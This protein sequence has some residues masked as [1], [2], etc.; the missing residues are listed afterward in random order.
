[1]KNF[2]LPGTFLLLAL[3]TLGNA[4]KK[5]KALKRP[6]ALFLVFSCL[7]P[8]GCNSEDDASK[9]NWT[10]HTPS[11]PLPEGQGGLRVT[12]PEGADG[13]RWNVYDADNKEVRHEEPPGETTLLP[14]GTYLVVL[15]NELGEPPVAR[16]VPVHQGKITE[17]SLGAVLVT[18]PEGAKDGIW[19]LFDAAGE[20]QLLHEI[21]P[22][23]LY[24]LPQGTYQ[25]MD[26]RTPHTLVYGEQISIHAG[27]ATELNLAAVLVTV[28]E[29]AIGG[30]WDLYDVAGETQLLHEIS[31]NVPSAVPSGT[32]RLMDERTPNT[33]PYVEKI[34]FHAGTISKVDLGAILVTRTGLERWHLYDA[35]GKI[36]LLH[37][38]SAKVPC[39]V[40]A[41]T[42]QIKS[43]NETIIPRVTV[44]PGQLTTTQ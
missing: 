16:D 14:P 31:A 12:I 26:E 19:S 7:L 40:P 1:M 42:Y 36:K 37:D 20:V 33:L 25:M 17:L 28:P 8:L 15:G 6:L 10:I 39:A 23:V 9:S 13:G 11:E 34:S 5:K 4:M 44:L 32:Y 41:G 35:S 29:G 22:N 2:I 43:Y 21:S 27:K 18:V 3:T 30:T 24:A 38:V